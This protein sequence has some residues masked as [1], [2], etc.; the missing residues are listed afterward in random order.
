MGSLGS[1]AEASPAAPAPCGMPS[2]CTSAQNRGHCSVMSIH[3]VP[4]SRHSLPVSSGS[5][6]ASRV[7]FAPLLHPRQ[8]CGHYCC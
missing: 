1:T 5:K 4:A 6:R 8:Q 7:P 2:R 3:V